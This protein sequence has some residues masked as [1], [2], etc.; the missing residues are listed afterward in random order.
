MRHAA[1]LCSQT[2]GQL[3]FEVCFSTGEI[4]RAVDQRGSTAGFWVSGAYLQDGPVA[5]RL[6]GWISSRSAK[7]VVLTWPRRAQAESELSLLRLCRACYRSRC[8]TIGILP[9]AT[10]GRDD[11]LVHVLTAASGGRTKN[12]C[13][14]SLHRA[15]VH[16]ICSSSAFT[17]ANLPTPAL[18]A[19]TAVTTAAGPHPSSTCGAPP[20]GG[21][22]SGCI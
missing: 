21:F 13:P 10:H 5:N 6:I 3:Y 1:R 12:D 9:A 4:A 8:P 11:P 15:G 14:C 22:L 18:P 16:G 17:R 7:G 20:R 19:A 2:C